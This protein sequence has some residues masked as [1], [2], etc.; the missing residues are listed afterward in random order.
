MSVRV[1][2]F[3]AL[4]N[5]PHL[6][7]LIVGIPLRDFLNW[8]VYESFIQGFNSIERRGLAKAMRWNVC[9]TGNTCT[10]AA[11]YPSSSQLGYNPYLTFTLNRDFNI[12]IHF[13]SVE[14]AVSSVQINL[15]VW[16]Q[17]TFPSTKWAPSWFTIKYCNQSCLVHSK[18]YRM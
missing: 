13:W 6:R 4:M 16:T 1:I 9:S 5:W 7:Q 3:S 15:K 14:T 17:I 8:L 10:S 11:F 2:S 12:L 18:L